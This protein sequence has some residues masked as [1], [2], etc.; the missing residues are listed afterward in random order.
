MIVKTIKKLKIL[1]NNNAK[2]KI[3]LCHGVFD[4]IHEG[5]INHFHTSKK[6]CDILIVSIT[7]D[8]FVKKGP[9]QPYNSSIKRAKVLDALKYI[10]YVYIN[11]DLTSINLI[12]ILKP[13]LYFKGLDY[14]KKDLTGN[15]KKEIFALKKNNGR[16]YFTKTK[17]MSSTKII[18]NILIN[19]TKEQKDLLKKIKNKYSLNYIIEQFEKIKN[20]KLD[21][22]GEPIIDNYVYSNII[23]LASKDAT[24]S[25]VVNNRQAISGGVLSVAQTASLFLK[26]VRLFSYG[27]NNFIK[28]YLNTNVKLINLNGKQSFQKK[29]RYINN[30]RFQKIFQLTN[31]E[32]NLFDESS[33]NKI[34]KIFK[35]KLRNNII[36][37]DFGIG[38]F[39]N[40][41]LDYINNSKI[42]KYINVQSNSINFG[43]NLFTKYKASKLIKYISLDEREWKLGIKSNQLDNHRLKNFIN[44]ESA[45]SVTLG[46][47]GSVYHYKNKNFYSPVFVDKV[48]DTT[49]CGD[50]YFIITS[51]LIII[52]TKPD[53]ISFLGNVY[54]GMHAMN[55]GN[56]NIPNKT[57][58]LKYVKSLLTI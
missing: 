45:Y 8:Q 2:K 13:N 3:G 20:L 19:W 42:N 11:K 52:K 31:F 46:K 27:N 18:N 48:V 44:N 26:E 34:I 22:I 24:L 40:K 25:G 36:I 1:R 17:V 37:C 23:G 5:H 29:T 56:N 14:L 58:Y 21:I 9:H 12:N 47:N 32:K 6:N 10:D 28:S 57:D 16:I 54:A 53:L 30:H 15:L 4:V 38:L 7:A 49:G 50:A 35:D 33:Q 51:L 39:E 41:I 55:L 43:F